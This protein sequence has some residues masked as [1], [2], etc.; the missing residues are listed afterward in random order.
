M[1][2]FSRI[3]ILLNKQ[4][5]EVNFDFEYPF[6]PLNLCLVCLSIESLKEEKKK[7]KKEGGKD[8]F[9]GCKIR[10]VFQDREI[11][12]FHFRSKLAKAPNNF[13]LKSKLIGLGRAPPSFVTPPTN[14][15][16]TL[17]G[18]H[19]SDEACHGN[20]FWKIISSITPNPL[21]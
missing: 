13:N 20:Q 1:N 5:Y 17:K 14:T 11:W 18:P 2:W 10:V 8:R 3:L 9:L 12:C 21:H 6:T 4:K 7:K 15:S 19:N 16:K